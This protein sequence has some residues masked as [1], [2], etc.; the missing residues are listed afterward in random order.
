MPALQHRQFIKHIQKTA[1]QCDDQLAKQA[2]A[3]QR[4]DMISQLADPRLFATVQ[5]IH[6][7]IS[8]KKMKASAA[9]AFLRGAVRKMIGPSHR[10][11]ADAIEES[12]RR[13]LPA[14]AI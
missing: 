1:S 13:V 3:G 12:W 9:E 11:P 6:R 4:D 14:A 7:N 5:G 2:L 10:T 8:V